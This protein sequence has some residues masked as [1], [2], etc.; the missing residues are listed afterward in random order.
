[1]DDLRTVAVG[2][3]VNVIKIEVGSRHV[4]DGAANLARDNRISGS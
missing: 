2:P 3:Q 4:F 1:M